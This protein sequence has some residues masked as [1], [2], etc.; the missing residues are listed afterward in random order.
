[1]SDTKQCTKCKDE[2]PESDFTTRTRNGRITRSSWCKPCKRQISRDKRRAG[3]W[4]KPS[5]EQLELWRLKGIEDRADV[6]K[7]GR[8][9][10]EDSRKSDRR[11]GFDN[12]LTR[13]AIEKL[14]SRPCSYCEG[15][16]DRMTLDRIDNDIGHTQ[17]N[18][19]P[20][21]YR[22]NIVRGSMPYEAW[23]VLAPS[24]KVAREN[25]LFG[26]WGLQPFARGKK[27]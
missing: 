27:T 7:R 2:Y 22:C 24:M 4:S 23:L 6:S 18:V 3:D 10:L 17:A 26:D 25:G 21:C 9:I 16:G 20:A 19:V 1:M 14:I 8:F 11:R 12:D 5:D 13:G 15:T